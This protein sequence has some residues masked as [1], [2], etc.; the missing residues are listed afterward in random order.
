MFKKVSQS[1]IYE[2]IVDQVFES[3]MRG[4]LKPDDK[5]PNE[6]ELSNIFGVSRVT[7]R[8]AIRAL[9]Q[10]GIIEVRQGSAGGSYVKHLG[11]DDVSEQIIKVFSMLNTPFPQLSDARMG[12]EGA[13]FDQLKKNKVSQEEFLELENNIA[14]AELF[15][16]QGNSAERMRCNFD[17]HSK[18]VA[19]SGNPIYMVVHR[20]IVFFSHKFFESVQPT[21]AMMRKTIEGHYEIV[22]YMKKGD[23]DRAGEIY[24]KHIENV[25]E[26]IIQKSKNQAKLKNKI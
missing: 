15:V 19:L 5:L 22:N 18:L 10:Y 24:K 13:V 6:H 9:E 4:D 23:F 3:I 16:K 2:I 1:R 11:V 25:S 17:F 20:V 14:K 7:V 21:E 8:E 12:I 26:L